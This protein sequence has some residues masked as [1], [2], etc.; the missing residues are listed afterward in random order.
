MV[1][2]NVSAMFSL[3]FGFC[4]L[5][6]DPD[7][8]GDVSLQFLISPLASHVAFCVEIMLYL[9]EELKYV[10]QVDDKLAELGCIAV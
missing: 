8:N 1:D 10:F 2:A 3:I 9:C 6:H 4:E 7:F 5:S